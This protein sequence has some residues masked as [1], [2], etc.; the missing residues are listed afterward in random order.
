[1]RLCEKATVEHGGAALDHATQLCRDGHHESNDMN[2]QRIS[3]K[4]YVAEPGT[5]DMSKIIPVFHRWIQQS[6][7]PGMLIDV[8]DYRHMFNGPGVVLIGYD[9]DYALDLSEGRM[10]LVHTSKR[11]SAA[12]VSDQ[13]AG[14]MHAGLVACQSFE[15]EKQL[16]SKIV[17]RTDEVRLVFAD[18]LNTPNQTS[19][20]D[21]IRAEITGLFDA[22]YEGAETRIERATEDERQCLTARITASGAPDLST[23]IDRLA[24]RTSG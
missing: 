2:P 18:R 9:V 10:G 15:K 13:V 19:T 20:F 5:V 4:Y 6:S 24:A 17:F 22:V 3:V 16:A 21:L 14:A 1:M 8:A 7:V 12:N 23:L 11:S